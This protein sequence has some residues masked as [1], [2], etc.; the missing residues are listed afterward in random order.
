ML[1]ESRQSTNMAD[2]WSDSTSDEEDGLNEIV[3]I[4]QRFP[5]RI[6]SHYLR[7][8]KV[9]WQRSASGFWRS[10]H[11][12]NKNL[13]RKVD[14]HGFTAVSDY[15]VER[16]A[17]NLWSAGGKERFFL[18]PSEQWRVLGQGQHPPFERRFWNTSHGQQRQGRFWE[19]VR[20][21][22]NR[23]LHASARG[24]PERSAPGRLVVRHFQGKW[25]LL[26]R[27][28]ASVA[29]MFHEVFPCLPSHHTNNAGHV[30]L[31]P[32]RGYLQK[33]TQSKMAK[34]WLAFLDTCYLE[35]KL[36]YTGK[37][38][39]EKKIYTLGGLYKV[40]GFPEEENT[41]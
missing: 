34:T 4:I 17:E 21:E 11:R 2:W 10:L 41:V 36:Q 29:P 14:I 5:L 3:E 27:W 35:G 8:G 15:A 31:V 40:D 7:T 6:L 26:W 9:Y 25:G 22:H 39:G 37:D 12:S 16:H 13:Q 33:D 32:H 23:G 38:A 19:V 28:C 1:C 24:I 20:Q 30:G 18:L